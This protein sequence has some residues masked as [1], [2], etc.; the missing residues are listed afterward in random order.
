MYCPGCLGRFY[1]VECFDKAKRHTD[2]DTPH[3][4]HDKVPIG[5]LKNLDYI[6]WPNEQTRI[7][8]KELDASKHDRSIRVDE[9]DYML[10]FGSRAVPLLRP[11]PVIQASSKCPSSSA[12]H[13]P[14]GRG[15]RLPTRAEHTNAQ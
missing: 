12:A 4:G 7:S 5:L 13:I 1:H 9:R 3:R 15:H 10:T 8:G 6:N 11:P 14:D 2:R